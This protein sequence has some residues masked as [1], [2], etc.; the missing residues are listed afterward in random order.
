MD[1]RGTTI[2]EKTGS[3]ASWK[4][5]P[6]PAKRH[7]QKERKLSRGKEQQSRD[8]GLLGCCLAALCCWCF[9]DACCE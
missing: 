1:T 3:L 7:R 2:K 4:A 8:V 6:P 9:V 5:Q